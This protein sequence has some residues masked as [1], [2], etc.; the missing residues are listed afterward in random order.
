MKS[1]NLIGAL[2][3]LPLT[4][5]ACSY[6]R[7]APGTGLRGGPVGGRLDHGILDR[8]ARPEGVELDVQ[9]ERGDG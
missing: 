5:V 3:A 1:P 6:E 7:P 2:I 4:L 8:V 9:V